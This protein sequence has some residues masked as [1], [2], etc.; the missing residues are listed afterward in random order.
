MWLEPG[1][2]VIKTPKYSLLTDAPLSKD[3]IIEGG[4][5]QKDFNDLNRA[6]LEKGIAE[7]N[8]DIETLAKVEWDFI[9]SHPTSP[10]AINLACEKLTNGYNL[11]QEQIEFLGKIITDCP[12]DKS[13][14]ANFIHRLDIARLTANGNPIVD[15]DMTTPSDERCQLA[16]IVKNT[17]ANIFLWTFGHHGVESAVLVLQKSKNTTIH[18]HTA[19]LM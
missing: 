5:A 3:C 18:F 4:Q 17:K 7:Y 11:T 8:P 12:S 6:K 16:D 10:V 14:Y 15:L 9:V 2:Y 13:R 1:E 19:G